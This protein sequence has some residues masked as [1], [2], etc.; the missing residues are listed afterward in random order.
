MKGRAG[1]GGV[2]RLVLCYAMV[3]DSGIALGCIASVMTLSNY[4]HHGLN[5]CMSVALACCEGGIVSFVGGL[6]A[7]FV[8]ECCV[9]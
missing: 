6:K 8:S 9:L 3:R 1:D 2:T 5:N 4:K 7:C